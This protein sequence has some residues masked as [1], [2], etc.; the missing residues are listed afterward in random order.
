MAGRA[1]FPGLFINA[2]EEDYCCAELLTFTILMAGPLVPPST[3]Q[4][5]SCAPGTRQAWTVS[6]PAEHI[7]ARPEP[8]MHCRAAFMLYTNDGVLGARHKPINLRCLRSVPRGR[9]GLLANS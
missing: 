8:K 5:R 2:T 4:Q 7:D 3:G 6:G 1:Y 9:S